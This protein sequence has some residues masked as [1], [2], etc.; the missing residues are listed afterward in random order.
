MY[1]LAR[2]P[3]NEEQLFYSDTRLED[4]ATLSFDLD[5]DGKMIK[6]V[7]RFFKGISTVISLPFSFL[8]SSQLQ[9]ADYLADYFWICVI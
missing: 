5:V 1:L 6:D 8:S 7:M 4:L 3:S 2:C 9:A